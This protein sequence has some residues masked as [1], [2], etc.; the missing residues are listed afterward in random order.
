MTAP[1]LAAVELTKDYGDGPALNSVSLTIDVGERIALVGHNGS[2]KTTLLR[3]A[4]GLL[5]ATSGRL[6]I[7]GER[8]VEIDAR[9]RLSYL[10]DTP[11]F[12]DDL[13][14]WE[15]LEYTARL[16]GVTDWVDRATRLLVDLGIDSRANELP[17]RFSRGLKQKAAIATALVRPFDLLLVDEPFVGLDTMGRKALLSSLD[18]ASERGATLVVATHEPSFLD[19]VSRVVILRDGD[20]VHDGAPADEFVRSWI[21]SPS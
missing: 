21:H 3:I 20:I 14:V 12:Y 17:G 10:A 4:A 18:D 6:E 16:H 2:G 9:R 7:F 19:R 15:H 1:A 5:D 13:S 11:V 8:P